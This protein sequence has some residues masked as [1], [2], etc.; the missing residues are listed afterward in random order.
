MEL[1]ARAWCP[2]SGFWRLQNPPDPELIPSE[3]WSFPFAVEILGPEER[4]QRQEEA[5]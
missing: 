3:V 5:L 1:L 4:I 2:P